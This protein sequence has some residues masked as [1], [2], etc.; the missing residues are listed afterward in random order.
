M[1]TKVQM[2]RVHDFG[3]LSVL[4]LLTAFG[5][6]GIAAMAADLNVEV[7]DLSGKPLADTV[8]FVTPLSGSPHR[9][10]HTPRT[11]I[12]QVNKEFTPLVS[13]VETGTEV[14]FPNSD[15]I[16][17]S[18]YSFSPAKAF[19]AKLYSGNQ[20]PPV[21]F[22]NSGLVVLGCNIHDAM[23]AWVVVV[24]TPYFAKTVAGGAADSD[25]YPTAPSTCPEC[26][27]RNRRRRGA[28]GAA[29]TDR[30]SID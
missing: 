6:V 16:R 26:C 25:A 14:S 9:P 17:H 29:P 28:R 8:V 15:N 12:D 10:A 1:V 22:D 11:T 24:D 20:A 18:I 5:F 21:I 3:W 4:A 13:I 2:R 7:R 19:T 30:R 23:V 27:C